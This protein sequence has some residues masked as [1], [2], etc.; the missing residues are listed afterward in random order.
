MLVALIATG[1]DAGRIDAVGRQA[2]AALGDDVGEL[3]SLAWAL[4]TD[5]ANLARTRS[6][7]L[8]AAQ[9]MTA[10]DGWDTPSRLDTLALARF[11]NGDVDGAIAAQQQ[12][13]GKLDRPDAR[14]QERLDRY[15]QAKQQTPSR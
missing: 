14:Y 1:A 11:E 13:I 5:A 9:A 10:V 3:N 2:V 15:L 7:A 8:R 4:L 6:T 12:A